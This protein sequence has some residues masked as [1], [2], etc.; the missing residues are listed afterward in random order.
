LNREIS[1]GDRLWAVATWL[2]TAAVLALYAALAAAHPAAYTID[3]VMQAPFPSSLIAAPRGKAVAWVLDTRG[4]RNIWVADAAQG[5]KARP[6][7]TFSG[8]DGFNIGELAWSPDAE[9]IAFTRGQTLEDE[10]GANVTSAPLGPSPREVWVVSAAGGD[11]HKVGAGHSPAFS[12]DGRRLVFIDKDR[13]WT[14]APKGSSEPQPLVVDN[15]QIASLTFSPDGR[16]LAFVSARSR[17]DLVGVYDFSTQRIAW[18]GPSLDHDNSPVFS[19]SGSQVAFIRVPAHSGPEFV[20]RRSG[21]PWSIW[22]ADAA[23]G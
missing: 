15:G 13:L 17:H 2:T 14:V 8:D 16:R 7:T 11:A 5:M 4:S 1:I 3:Q 23:S 19:P 20:S 10:R 12:P 6:I 9:L 18:M 21:E 22:V